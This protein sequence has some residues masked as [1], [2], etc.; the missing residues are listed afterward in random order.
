MPGKYE[1]FGV[2]NFAR[3]PDIAWFSEMV[4][5]LYGRVRPIRGGMRAGIIHKEAP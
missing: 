2:L 5:S 3:F 4:S 1:F